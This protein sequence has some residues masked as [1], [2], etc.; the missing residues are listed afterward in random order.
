M[1]I[2]KQT[3]YKAF[4]QAAFHFAKPSLPKLKTPEPVQ[5]SEST[6]LV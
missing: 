4:K 5:N 1:C 3:P 2:S 6:A